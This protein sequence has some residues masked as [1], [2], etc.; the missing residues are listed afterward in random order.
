MS[1]IAGKAYGWNVLVPVSGGLLVALLKKLSF[2]IAGVVA[3]SSLNGLRTLSTIHYARWVIVR[4]SDFP[5]LSASQPKE[6]LRYSYMFFFSDFNGAWEEYV[7][8]FSVAIPGS[9]NLIWWHSV[10][11]PKAAPMQPFHAYIVRNQIYTNYYYGAYP[12]ASVNDIKSSRNVRA[13]VSKL[14]ATAMAAPPAD[15]LKQYHALLKELQHD[16]ARLGPMAIVSLA[17]KAA[18]EHERQTEHAPR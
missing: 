7:D 18:E 17:A 8:A 2:R 9:L 6:K 1:N 11:W 13:G 12:M 5:R 4:A 3:P 14:A 16:L 10:G 15:F